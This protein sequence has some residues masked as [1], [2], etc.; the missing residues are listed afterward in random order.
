MV[1]YLVEMIMIMK[2]NNDQPNIRTILPILARKWYYFNSK[3]DIC[4][5]YH[6][7]NEQTW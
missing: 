7:D 6:E 3:D 5:R 2:I 1:G 4:Q